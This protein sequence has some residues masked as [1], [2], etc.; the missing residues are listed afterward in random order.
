MKHPKTEEWTDYVRGTLESGAR[1]RL[2]DHLSDG[3]DRCEREM[4]AFK[5]V[6][7][8]AEADLRSEPPRAAISA[9]K[10]M[11]R[12]QQLIESSEPTRLGLDVSFDSFLTPATSG[13]RGSHANERHLVFRSPQLLVDL[14]LRAVENGKPVRLRG[15]LLDA[16]SKPL[17]GVPAFLLDRGRISSQDLSGRVGD[18]SLEADAKSTPRLCLVVGDDLVEVPLPGRL[19]NLEA[20]PGTH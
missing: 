1:A 16:E 18:F 10:N 4:D 2:G 6:H 20:N 3:C 19:L 14:E 15:Q 17:A 7:R 9:A 13:V 12:V 8:L 11:F 5:V